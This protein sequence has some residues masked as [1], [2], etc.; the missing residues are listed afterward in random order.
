MPRRW[1]D[2][3]FHFHRCVIRILRSNPYR[4]VKWPSLAPSNRLTHTHTHTPLTPHHLHPSPR[5]RKRGHTHILFSGRD[6]FGLTI[7]FLIISS[8]ELPHLALNGP[9]LIALR[10]HSYPASRSSISLPIPAVLS[11]LRPPPS[12]SRPIAGHLESGYSSIVA[13]FSTPAH[14][15]LTRADSSRL[16]LAFKCHRELLLTTA[17]IF[18]ANSV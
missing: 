1:R 18:I 9:A 15:E 5:E 14:R 2:K 3:D 17:L 16:E 8:V 11:H 13:C 7:T 12:P 6:A 4:P 10:I